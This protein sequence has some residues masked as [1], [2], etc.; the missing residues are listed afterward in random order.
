MLYKL[1]IFFIIDDEITLN[2]EDQDEEDEDK[3]SEDGE[4]E[5]EESEVEAT[6]SGMT[7]KDGTQ[8]AATSPSEHQAGRRNIVRER[9]GPN[10]NTNLLSN[11][12]TFKLF[13]TP[14][15]ADIIIRHTNKKAISTYTEYNEKN[16]E[17]KQLEWKTLELQL[18]L[19]ILGYF[20]NFWR[21]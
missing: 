8:W 7:A 4:N 5:D 13:F 18:I 12:D 3:E 2:N 20:D 9:C 16:P 10:R 6:G 21:Q 14:E 11:L 17:K 15:M 19:C 1:C